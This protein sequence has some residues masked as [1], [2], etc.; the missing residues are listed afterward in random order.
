MQKIKE[1]FRKIKKINLWQSKVRTKIIGVI[2][3]PVFF[4][5]ILGIVSYRKSSSDIISTYETSSFATLEMMAD[6]FALGFETV[7]NKANQFI[8]NDSIKRYYSGNYEGDGVKEAEQFRSVQNLLASSTMNDSVVQDVFIFADYGSGVST[9]GT[10]PKELY[11]RYLDSDEGK[12]FID[13]KAR[14]AL[15]KGKGSWPAV[16]M[17]PDSSRNGNPWP[18]CG[19]ID[20]IEHTGNNMNQLFFSLHSELHNHTRKDTKQNTKIVYKEGVCQGFHDYHME[21]TPDYIEYFVDGVSVCRFNKS[22]NKED[23]TE[24]SWPYDQP[25]YLILNIAVGGTFGGEVDDTSFPYVMEVEHVRVY[26]KN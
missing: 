22:D 16:W 4:I 2:I 17:M 19:E 21:W 11:Q 8:T 1:V 15:S 13:S 26:Q 3:I 9:R 7:T 23:Q 20:I 25:F 10:V 24:A 5:I 6:K 14:F 12:D 18:R